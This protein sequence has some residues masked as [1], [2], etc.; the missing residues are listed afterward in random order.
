MPEAMATEVAPA[1]TRV[2]IGTHPLREPHVSR[3]QGPRCRRRG[4]AGEVELTRG[5]PAGRARRPSL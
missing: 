4:P 5:E 2:K 1:F 3:C